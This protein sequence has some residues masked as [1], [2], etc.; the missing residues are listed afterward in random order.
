[1]AQRCVGNIFLAWYEV[2][3]II[4]FQFNTFLLY[5]YAYVHSTFFRFGDYK[6]C[7]STFGRFHRF[8]T[9]LMPQLPTSLCSGANYIC[10]NSLAI[11]FLF[12][13][14]IFDDFKIEN[15]TFCQ[16]LQLSFKFFGGLCLIFCFRATARTAIRT[17]WCCAARMRRCT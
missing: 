12:S 10:N 3:F 5:R 7:Y 2:H 11:T 17:T 15:T 6:R 14:T 8:F 9:I 13:N 4:S 1:M 16:K